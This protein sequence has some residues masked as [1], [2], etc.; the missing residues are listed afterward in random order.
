MYMFAKVTEYQQP[1]HMCAHVL[2]T[3]CGCVDYRQSA[4][5]R[6]GVAALWPSSWF[7]VCPEEQLWNG[8]L[9][10]YPIRRNTRCHVTNQSVHYL[11]DLL[12]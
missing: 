7:P 11:F 1:V 5:T 8:I 2:L 12:T 9:F 3:V 6:V 4:V 10:P